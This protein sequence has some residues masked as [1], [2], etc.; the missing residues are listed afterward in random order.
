MILD[1]ITDKTCTVHDKTTDK[2]C[3]VHDKS[4]NKTSIF[5]DIIKNKLY[6]EISKLARLKFMSTVLLTKCLY[7]ICYFL[8]QSIYI[9]EASIY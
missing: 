7:N 4:T 5:T 1:N 8:L 9:I 3:A 2:T 6:L